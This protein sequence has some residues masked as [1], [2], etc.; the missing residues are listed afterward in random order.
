[1]KFELNDTESKNLI[2][3]VC[4]AE[5]MV[6]YMNDHIVDSQVATKARIWGKLAEK[7]LLAAK[8]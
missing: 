2:R 3:M 5:S 4:C 6:G 7:L 1:M 8:E